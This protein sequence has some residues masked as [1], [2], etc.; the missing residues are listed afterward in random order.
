MS[1]VDSFVR[2]VFPKKMYSRWRR[3]RDKKAGKKY[4][5]PEDTLQWED[6]LRDARMDPVLREMIGSYQKHPWQD[7]T[8]DYW[9][10]LNK[11][12]V[13]QLL[14]NSFDNF[15]QTIALNY[16]T[17]LIS[18]D[19]FHIQFL[20]DNVSPEALSWAKKSSRK[21][22]RHAFFSPRQSRLYNFMTFLLWKYTEEQLGS[23]LMNRLS[24]PLTG[25][26]PAVELEGRSISQDLANSALEF[27]SI[28]GGT[29]D[30]QGIKT[31]L[32]LG[33]GYGRTAQVMLTLLPDIRYIIVDIPP[34][35]YVAQRYLGTV[36]GAK[37]LFTFRDFDDFS[38]VE[39]EFGRGQILFLLPSQL[40]KLPPKSVDLAA[41]INCLHEMRPQRLEF[42]F[43]TFDRIARNLYFTCFKKTSIPYDNIEL[44]EADYPVRSH[45]QKIFWRTRR[46]QTNYFEALFSLVGQ[47]D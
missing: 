10:V 31:V 15:K 2:T 44:T 16:F 13:S 26:P 9:Q 43:H 47:G 3:S 7:T 8:S 45:W 35:L 6:L 25:N 27:D 20:K 29:K 41:A 18:K 19:H 40:E 23:E 14:E 38:E 24:E 17:W 37:R 34:A 42:Y 32:E 46:V 12:N 1:F 30:F 11:K 22:R 36:F 33:A 5:E 28:S 21:A 39:E 4:Y